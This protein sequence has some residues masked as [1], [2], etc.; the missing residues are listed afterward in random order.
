MSML[1][2]P[3]HLVFVQ[4]IDQSFCSLHH[5]SLADLFKRKSK[6]LLTQLLR[7]VG[8]AVEVDDLGQGFL[9]PHAQRTDA[10][11]PRELLVV[12]LQNFAKDFTVDANGI[13]ECTV[14]I[15][16]DVCH[17]LKVFGR[18][19]SCQGSR[20]YVAPNHGR[21]VVLLLEG[22]GL[23]SGEQWDLHLDS[24]CTYFR[25]LRIQLMK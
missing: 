11:L 15:E 3:P 13:K 7:A 9:P 8:K 1:S 4:V 20:C 6:Q 22:R 16:Y 10:E 5:E 21:L 23:A 25:S 12:S 18:R 24:T 14:D 17:G 2:H 19:T